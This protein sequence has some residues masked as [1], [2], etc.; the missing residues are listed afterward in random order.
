MVFDEKMYLL[1]INRLDELKKEDSDEI[2][3]SLDNM[4]ENRNVFGHYKNL[5]D[6]N[7]NEI[8]PENWNEDIEKLMEFL[9]VKSAS[10]LLITEVDDD[11][12]EMYLN[13]RKFNEL[14]TR[15]KH[16]VK[17]GIHQTKMFTTWAKPAYE[18]ALSLTIFSMERFMKN[19]K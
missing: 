14:S 6:E 11:N 18:A 13:D 16:L 19:Q 10:E 17:I 4:D 7:N 15:D 3:A 5:N 2:E 1:E 9:G 12:Y 8:K